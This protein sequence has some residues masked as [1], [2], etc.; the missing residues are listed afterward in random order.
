MRCGSPVVPRSKGAAPMDPE[1][2]VTRWIARLK[3]GDRAAAQALWEAYFHRLVALARHRLRGAR[4]APP[5]RRTSPWPPSTASTA[6]PNAASSPGS[7]TATTSGSSCSSSPCARPLDL[8]RREARRPGRGARGGRSG[9]RPSWTS[10]WSSA[11]SRPPSSPPWWPTSA[12]DCSTAWG[13]RRC[14]R[15][16]SGRWRARPTPRSPR[17]SGASSRPSSASC[18]GSATSGPGR[19]VS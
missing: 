8:A 13:T 6:A 10:S 5:T 17:G 14:A 11:R 2:S 1:G 4:A 19:G 16:R 9:S 3:D 12:G 18:S 15:W 7:R